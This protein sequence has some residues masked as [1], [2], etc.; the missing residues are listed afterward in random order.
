MDYEVA[1][2]CYYSAATRFWGCYR[3][4]KEKNGVTPSAKEKNEDVKDGV[5]PS[6]T[7]AS[8]NSIGTQE[9]NLVKAGNDNLHDENV[10]ETPSNFTA[11]PNKG[12]FYA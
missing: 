7:V 2:H 4:V 1:P 9:A 8:E 3:G 10:E 5:T 6:V 11:N 12:T